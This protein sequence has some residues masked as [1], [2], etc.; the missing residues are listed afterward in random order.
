MGLF[1][2]KYR[3]LVSCKVIFNCTQ[4]GM[5]VSLTE[6]VADMNVHSIQ[7]LLQHYSSKYFSYPGYFELKK[8][9]LCLIFDEPV[10]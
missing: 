7:W 1:P 8:V 10:D 5:L 3:A 2:G 4:F 9:R 6:L